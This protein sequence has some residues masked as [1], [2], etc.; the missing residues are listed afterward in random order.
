V[1]C[2]RAA[3]DDGRNVD[4]STRQ[5]S[6]NGI[7]ERGIFVANPMCGVG[8]IVLRA[9][10]PFPYLYLFYRGVPSASVRAADKFRFEEPEEVGFV[11]RGS[12]HR[13]EYLVKEDGWAGGEVE[14]SA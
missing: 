9:I 8:E 1:G 5:V 6:A 12:Q 4:F 14:F 13:G 11:C 3:H 10:Y 2:A 7:G